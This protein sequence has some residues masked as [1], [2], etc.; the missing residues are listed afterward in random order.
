MTQMFDRID[1]VSRDWIGMPAVWVPALLGLLAL[2]GAVAGWLFPKFEASAML[3]FPEPK[4]YEQSQLPDPLLKQEQEQK[5]K[6][7]VIE[8]HAYK[9]VAASYHS[10]AQLAAY[11]EAT[12]GLDSAAGQRLLEQSEKPGFWDGVAV[13]VLPFS[14]RDQKQFG[15]IRDPAANSVLGLELRASARAAPVAEQ[16]IGIL[17][18]YFANSMVREQIRSW[19]LAGKV[20]ALSTQKTAHADIVR[21]ELDIELSARR[22]E[23][24]KAILARYPQA[25]RMESSQALIVTEPG[26]RFLSPLAQLVGAESAI[27]QRREL[28]RR[29]ER[30]VRQKQLLLQFYSAA[31]PITG[32]KP[33]ALKILA[34]LKELAD[35]TF[36]EVDTKEEWA[37][38]ATLRIYGA[39]EGFTALRGQFGVR[40]GVSI[41]AAPGRAPIRLALLGAVVGALVLGAF[42]LLRAS[43]R[44][45]RF[46][47]PDDT[48][49]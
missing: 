38:E 35:E 42:A 22:A 25:G 49:R 40:G 10:S 1:K 14:R 48:P 17:S 43:L 29:L 8:L 32:Q 41:E 9:R 47:M 33:D 34:V 18:G 37:R 36:S 21:A 30:D 11:L 45:A 5:D 7:N 2:A 6:G 4:K 20:A 3:Q 24:M 15:D 31:E 46:E 28:I 16:M 26:E 27:S 44:A 13:P 19:V 39:L 12:G 23:D